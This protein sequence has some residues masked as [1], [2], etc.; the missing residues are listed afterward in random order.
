MQLSFRE[1]ASW[2]FRHAR[3]DGIF[4]LSCHVNGK[5]YIAENCDG[6]V[7]PIDSG[8]QD[9]DSA[10]FA[11]LT[12][13]HIWKHACT[14][15]AERNT[16]YDEWGPLLDKS[17]N[18]TTKMPGSNDVWSNNSRPMV[19][20]GFQ[21][22]EVKTGVVLYSNVLYYNA[23]LLLAEMAAQRGDRATSARCGN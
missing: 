2:M 8:C 23:S 17:L 7:R 22:N 16:W 20:Y 6:S 14:T 5:C 21:D 15:V 11:T 13:A 12:A 18:A 1:S 3:E 19:G 10:P 4:P 9:L